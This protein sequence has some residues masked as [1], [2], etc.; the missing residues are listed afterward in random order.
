[1]TGWLILITLAGG[2]G[3]AVWIYHHPFRACPRC[4]G[5]G[6]NRM[7]TARRRGHC[8]RCKGSREIQA[9]G[10]RMI[11]RAVRSARTSWSGKEN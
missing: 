7:S 10:S 5:S 1:M 8:R 4:K 2:T 3:R 6:R 11:H 9:R